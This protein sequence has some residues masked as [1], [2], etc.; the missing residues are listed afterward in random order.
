MILCIFK[1]IEDSHVRDN[2]IFVFLR[3][4]YSKDLQLHPFS[5]N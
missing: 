5:A 4:A 1:N 2:M 3:Q